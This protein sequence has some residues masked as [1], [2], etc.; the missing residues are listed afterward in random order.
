MGIASHNE[1]AVVAFTGL[2]MIL[3]WL[4]WALSYAS[5]DS[6]DELY[7]DTIGTFDTYESAEKAMKDNISQDIK[8]GDDEDKWEIN[9][10]EA[11]YVNDFSNEYKEYKI[12]A[13]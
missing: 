11:K 7:V 6:D 12:K 4:V 1:N 9:G 3:W 13:L 5:I 10:N 8:D 2:C